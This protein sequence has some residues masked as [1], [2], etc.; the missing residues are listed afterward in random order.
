MSKWNCYELS[1]Y[2][3]LNNQQSDLF[4]NTC[5]RSWRNNHLEPPVKRK[6]CKSRGLCLHS[7][8]VVILPNCGAWCAGR[9]G[10]WLMMC[11]SIITRLF[12]FSNLPPL[13]PIHQPVTNN[14]HWTVSKITSIVVCSIFDCPYPH[15]W[16]TAAYEYPLAGLAVYY[17]SSSYNCINLAPIVYRVL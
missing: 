2:Y 5:W 10:S 4:W 15:Q 8:S 17:R 7:T 13:P 14:S 9:F 16:D 12:N 1:N 3:W 11:F 6:G